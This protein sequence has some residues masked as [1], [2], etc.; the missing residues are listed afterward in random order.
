MMIETSTIL[1][2]IVYSPGYDIHFLGLEKLHPFDSCK[3]SRTW[4]AL[5]E[6]FGDRLHQYR[7]NPTD[8]VTLEMLE[9]VHSDAYLTQLKISRRVAKALE[10]DSL[11]FLPVGILDHRVLQPMRLATK[12]T[13]IAAETSLETGIAINL[14]GGY[15]HASR[16]RGEGF[17]VYSD[18]AIAI[19][20]LRQS[21]KLAAEDPIAII[22]L[23]AHQGN[24]LERIFYS[25]AAVHI[26][27]M[28]NQDVYPNDPWAKTRIN[29]DLPLK[30]GTRDQEYLGKLQEHLPAF[31]QHCQPKIAFYNAG[32]DIYE[33]DPLGRLKISHQGVL[34]RDRI[35]FQSLVESKIPVVMV[36]S[37]GYTRESY[38][39]V[40]G[41]VANVLQTWGMNNLPK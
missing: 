10:L 6:K 36:L 17:C 35:I 11:G 19:A 9:T 20:L 18:I 8:P 21:Q 22:D 7:I 38:K 2:K 25:D 31:L 26:L 13:A 27:D 28:Y 40:A 41:S 16:D 37:G 23:D 15:H 33:Y 32:T 39:L 34:E 5:V 29:C 4:N 1:P 30:S 3:Y 14:S 24:G 12:G